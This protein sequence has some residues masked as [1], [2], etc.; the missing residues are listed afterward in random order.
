MATIYLIHSEK[1]NKVYVGSTTNLKERIA[2]HRNSH[3]NKSYCSSHILFNEYGFENCIFTILEK[4]EINIRYERERSWILHYPTATN[5][6][7]P[8]R[9]LEE[10]NE[11]HRIAVRKFRKMNMINDEY[12][13]KVNKCK[14]ESYYRHREENLKKKENIGKQIKMKLIEYEENVPK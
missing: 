3:I 11:L 2:H 12:R 13:D 7:I 6:C 1:G 5:I 4:C 8:A 14:M 9:P 10:I